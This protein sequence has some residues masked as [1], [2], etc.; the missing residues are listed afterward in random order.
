MIHYLPSILPPAR[1]T[2]T[3]IF[4][5]RFTIIGTRSI[6]ITAAA[7]ATISRDGPH[8]HHHDDYSVDG[9]GYGRG[10]QHQQQLLTLSGLLNFADGLMSSFGEERIF[11]FTTNHRERLDTAL[12]RCGRM[13][14]HILLSYCSFS[15]LKKLVFNYLQ[16]LAEH[17]LFGELE[18]AMAE[19]HITP[20]SVAEILIRD[21][22]DPDEA[23]RQVLAAA[24]CSSSADAA[25]AA[26]AEKPKKDP[27][28]D[29]NQETQ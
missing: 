9:H 7:A 16:G 11:I 21:R 6:S 20:A 13:D 22:K 25:A 1:C 10:K 27:T 15:A 18:L 23:L 3:T 8:G 28:T 2:T 14:M 12:L 4:T 29:Q 5:A 24:K 19:A 17:P 26:L